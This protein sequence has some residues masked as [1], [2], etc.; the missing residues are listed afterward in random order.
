MQDNKSEPLI[1]DHSVKGQMSFC[2][3]AL[4][5]F[6]GPQ[7]AEINIAPRVLIIFHSNL[8]RLQCSTS[9]KLCRPWCSL[10]VWDISQ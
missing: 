2:H 6:S 9:S 10:H 4:S 5:V 7:F 3:A 1:L 8:Y